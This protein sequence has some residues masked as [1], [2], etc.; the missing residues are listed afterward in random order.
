MAARKIFDISVPIT[1]AMP[2]YKGDAAVILERTAEVSRGDPYTLTRIGMSA[3]TGTHIDAPAHFI[4]GGRTIQQLDLDALI[5]PVRVVDLSAVEREITRR[6]LQSAERSEQV[7]RILLKTRNSALWGQQGFRED[8]VALAADGAQWLVDRGARLVGIDYLSVEAFGSLDF[9]AHHILLNA[10]VVVLEGVNLDGIAPG[11]YQL[12]CL[13]L[14]IEGAEG[15]PARAVL[16]P[17]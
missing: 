12:I 2:V 9:A 4:P 5:G 13:P 1:T 17:E 6:D 11:A 7:E 8:Y 10:G 16:I 14:R 15:A 3:H